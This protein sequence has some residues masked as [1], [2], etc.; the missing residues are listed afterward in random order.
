MEPYLSHLISSVYTAGFFYYTWFWYVCPVLFILL[1]VSVVRNWDPSDSSVQGSG[2]Q[3]GLWWAQQVGQLCSWGFGWQPRQV[4]PQAVNL[5]LLVA[6]G[7]GCLFW[8]KPCWRPKADTMKCFSLFEG[9]T[10]GQNDLTTQ[11]I[12]CKCYPPA[13][14]AESYSICTHWRFADP[15]GWDAV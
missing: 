11:C 15:V 9:D 14:Q 12:L 3:A 4:Q 1:C 2:E 6:Y 7:S 5:L 8:L 13:D 10:N